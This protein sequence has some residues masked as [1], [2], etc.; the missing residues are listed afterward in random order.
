MKK[1]MRS[2][3]TATLSDRLLSFAKEMREKAA[4]LLAGPEQEELLQK[5]QRAEDAAKEIAFYDAN[6]DGVPAGH[7]NRAKR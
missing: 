1:R 3:Q 4:A 5:A 7:R 6:V 2:K